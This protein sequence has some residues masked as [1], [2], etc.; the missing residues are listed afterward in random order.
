M[1]NL[2]KHENAT[3][4]LGTGSEIAICLRD[5]QRR[6]FERNCDDF[7]YAS[8]RSSFE[9]FQIFNS[10]GDMI[11]DLSRDGTFDI[12]QGL[13]TLTLFVDEGAYVL[14][15]TRQGHSLCLSIPA[16][17][18]WTL[19][20]YI[21][22]IVDPAE[23]KLVP[24]LT[25]VSISYGM[26]G[27]GF[28]PNASAP[29]HLETLRKEMLEG[30]PQISTFHTEH[31]FSSEFENPMFGLYVLQLLFAQSSSDRRLI[32]RVLEKIARLLGPMH[33]D[34]VAM[35]LHYMII[36]G[37][38]YNPERST[39]LHEE[40][41]LLRGP[42]ILMASW[43]ILLRAAALNPEALDSDS[44][45]ASPKEIISSGLF[46]KWVIFHD[47]SS[48]NHI[49]RESLDL[50]LE[51]FDSDI[52]D[53]AAVKDVR[54]TFKRLFILATDTAASAVEVVRYARSKD[55]SLDSNGNL[56]APIATDRIYNASDMA[57]ALRCVAGLYE[58]AEIVPTFRGRAGWLRRYSGL[59]GDL[60]FLFRDLA[61]EA[62][63]IELLD[64]RYVDRLLAARRVPMLVLAA[65][66]SNLDLCG[67]L[68][69]KIMKRLRQTP[70]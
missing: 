46:L 13:L 60:L 45:F 20:C 24:D 40:L 66:I 69:S 10:H 7:E 25:D 2:L 58:W 41:G 18:G 39:S 19:Q 65:A 31:I 3:L 43:D 50:L 44:I 42:P 30:R 1:N 57:F 53:N 59:E 51:S 63:A 15:H 32:T 6:N 37:S 54:R 28:D 48:W 47:D 64:S 16:S 8:Y 67:W 33:P 62:S 17:R 56:I 14:R 38:S 4:R 9:G 23:M 27:N 29:A 21:N 12:L 49:V 26:M 68:A 70:V 61:A 35:S 55:P 5:P 34:V 22:L 11:A 52:S 36:Y